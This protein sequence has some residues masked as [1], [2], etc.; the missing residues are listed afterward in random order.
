MWCILA[1]CEPNCEN[2]GVCL[3]DDQCK[4]K[5]LT[6]GKRCENGN[7]DFV[8]ILENKDI[9]VSVHRTR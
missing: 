3:R 4:C 5:Y 6:S 1:K 2:G 8:Y 9:N 7:D